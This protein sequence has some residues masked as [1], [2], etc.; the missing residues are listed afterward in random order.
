MLACHWKHLTS[1]G[2]IN[3]NCCTLLLSDMV[4][5]TTLRVASLQGFI[6][7]RIWRFWGD[8]EKLLSITQI[9]KYTSYVGEI[10]GMLSSIIIESGVIWNINL[11]M[12]TTATYPMMWKF[13]DLAYHINFAHI[14]F[15]LCKFSLNNN[16]RLVQF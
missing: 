13:I 7:S 2:N 3:R 8:S 11:Q 10:R 14:L 16:F 15:L 1:I 5:V 6:S 9:Q 4:S 12:T